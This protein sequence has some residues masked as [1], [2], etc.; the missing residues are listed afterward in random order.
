MKLENL[1]GWLVSSAVLLN[2][3]LPAENDFYR[4][5]V[6]NRR[7]RIEWPKECIKNVFEINNEEIP[8]N[9]KWKAG[10]ITIPHYLVSKSLIGEEKSLVKN[11][12]GFVLGDKYFTPY[13]V[14]DDVL[15]EGVFG[16]LFV[17][18]CPLEF[19]GGSAKHD[20]AVFRVPKELEEITN[21]YFFQPNTEIY[22][23]QQ[24]V[25]YR[26]PLSYFFEHSEGKF[27]RGVISNLNYGIS[28][29]NAMSFG[30]V[31]FKGKADFGD[32]G[33]PVFDAKTG[34]VLGMVT[35]KVRD[36]TGG[37]FAPVSWFGEFVLG[38]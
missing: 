37:Y 22:L 18:G 34:D 32:S 38:R 10:V 3:C 30:Y 35:N 17:S 6:F 14:A 25:I 28:R 19:I 1:L 8:E 31:G 4:R 26:N 7:P 15:S 5:E 13:H 2:A 27:E 36:G 23:G 9:I 29:K 16:N 21:D 12:T 33:S 11:G 24:I 20:I